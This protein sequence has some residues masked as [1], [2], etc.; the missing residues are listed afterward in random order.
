MI[1]N[2]LTI[3][4]RTLLRH[5]SFSLI[6]IVGLAVGLASCLL[7]FLY[8]SQE[9]SYDTFHTKAGRIA[10]VT[11]EYSMDGQ[12][13]QY[14]VTG[15]KVVPD[16]GRSFPEVESG[17][18]MLSGQAVVSNQSIRFREKRFVYADSAFFH[19]FSFP[20]LKGD[21]AKALAAPNQLVLS[22]SAAKKYFGDRNPVGKTLRIGL[23][24]DFMV[25]GVVAD[26]PPNSQIKY[27]ILASFTSLGEAKT[28]Q[29]WSANYASYLLLRTPESIRSLQAKIPAY[30][31][32]KSAETEMTG[33][34]YLTYFL[35]PMPEVHLHSAVAGVFEPAGN[36]TY[37]YIFGSIALLILVIACVNYI[38]LASARA[39]ERAQEVGV[40]KVMG[41]MQQQLF[42][43]FMGESLLVTF[44]ALLIGWLLS[45]LLLPFFN[46]LTD[47]QFSAAVW[48]DPRNLLMLLA[49]GVL[50]SLIAGSYPAL[51]LTRY[52]PVQVL[53][54][55]Q[56]GQ[57]ASRFRQSLIVFQFAITAFLIVSTLVVKRQL[58]FIQAKNL[59]YNKEHVLILPANRQ[60]NGQIAAVKQQLTG[61]S[62]VDHVS[63]VYESPTFVNG[64]YGMRRADMPENTYRMITGLPVDEGFVKTTG[65]QIVAGTDLT[66]QDMTRAG[67]P[68]AD[69]LNSYRFILNEAAVK[70][71]GWK[72]P[73]EA[74]GKRVD[75]G[76][77]RKGE[78]KAVVANFHFASMRRQISPIVMFTEFGGGNILVKLAGNDI[79]GTL[80]QVEATWKKL[81]PN[82]P[83]EYQFMDE[84]FNKLYNNETRTGQIFT[85]F[86]VLSILLACL[87]L[88]GL[89]AFTTAQRTK[90]IGIR[91]VLG[92]SVPGLIFLLSKDFLKL[93]LIAILIASPLAWYAMNTWLDEFAYKVSVEWWVFALTALLAIGIAFLTVSFQSLKAAW[94]NPVRSLR[95]E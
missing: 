14:G 64:G 27:D 88:F 67:D 40:R 16:F 11:M 34:N 80:R 33:K 68:K 19:L 61:L 90:E 95:S 93:V 54:G 91:K 52:R 76:G 7:L 63:F 74:I 55:H 87:G 4:F 20:L 58:S 31:R 48:L 56:K 86:T 13:G 23:D 69:T 12:V 70:D 82:Y 9:V 46:T 10:R 17:V 77:N 18:R 43:Q 5:R 51:V 47:R 59:G 29:W 15:T 25:T 85:V 89:S 22:A 44:T 35:E 60:V 6:T 24:K 2:Y 45:Y 8:I 92:A 1:R 28:E 39:V 71:F 38:N 78:V 32:T 3:A 21:P 36:I 53:K 72:T 42:S 73:Q 62:G 75:M 57:S 84:E 94:M 83:F 49:L 50:V 37:I 30:M 65:L 79:A 81:A 41:A 66:E 26:C